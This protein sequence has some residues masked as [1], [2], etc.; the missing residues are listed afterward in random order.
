MAQEK[1]KPL[2]EEINA[3]MKQA[4]GQLQPVQSYLLW[5]KLSKEEIHEAI[6]KIAREHG[7]VNDKKQKEIINYITETANKVAQYTREI[8]EQ[9]ADTLAVLYGQ[10]HEGRR[11]KFMEI[12]NIRDCEEILKEQM[13]RPTPPEGKELREVLA[14][15]LK[16]KP[17]TDEAKERRFIEFCKCLTLPEL[18]AIYE[19]MQPKSV[20]Y[21][22]SSPHILNLTRALSAMTNGRKLEDIELFEEK[23]G[24]IRMIFLSNAAAT[25]ITFADAKLWQG[26][27]DAR[28]LFLYILQKCNDQ[29]GSTC[30][31][32]L[33]DMVKDKLYA[34]TDAARR[35]ITENINTIVDGLDI[36]AVT[37]EQKEGKK[38]N[39]ATGVEITR[40]IKK[41]KLPPTSTIAEIEIDLELM[42]ALSQYYAAM[43]EWTFALPKNAFSLAHYIYT[44]ARMNGKN[45]KE[46]KHFNISMEAARKNMCLP[47]PEECSNK[48]A[49]IRNQIEKAIEDIEKAIDEYKEKNIRITPYMNNG[50]DITRARVNEW[51]KYGM[52]RVTLSGFYLDYN[53]R[54]GEDKEAEIKKAKAR[55]AKKRKAKREQ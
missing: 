43:P 18:I 27:G 13:H 33:R 28:K 54:R 30:Y 26:G 45:L 36:R 1:E 38:K 25:A 35:G 55:A 16:K 6:N 22:P 47:V 44:L 20:M 50:T 53:K 42:A 3:L 7:G 15:I 48:T 34:R 40:F 51:L 10:G 2:E 9:H 52:I 8:V 4:E 24:Q 49:Q 17:R 41:F 12:L 19:A 46:H 32:D 21:M 39:T 37:V 23:N 14:E 5:A 11:Y 31:I 29:G